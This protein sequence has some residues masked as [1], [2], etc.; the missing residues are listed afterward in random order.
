MP[1]IGV[2]KSLFIVKCDKFDL[3]DVRLQS[4]YLIVEVCV[5]VFNNVINLVRRL[6]KL[7][8]KPLVFLFSSK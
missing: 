4:V 5:H 1:V 8:S 6:L 3:G 7:L 2:N